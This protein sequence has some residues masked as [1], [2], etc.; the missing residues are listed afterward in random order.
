MVL[1]GKQRVDGRA[2]KQVVWGRGLY[3]GLRDVTTD[4]CEDC[5]NGASLDP[6]LIINR[7][8]IKPRSLADGS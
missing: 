5:G 6:L 7:K 2:V 3:S 1:G 4:E 8:I